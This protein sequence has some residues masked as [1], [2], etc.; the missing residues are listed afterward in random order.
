MGLAIFNEFAFEFILEEKASTGTY[1]LRFPDDSLFRHNSRSPN[2][3]KEKSRKKVC[4]LGSRIF[5][6]FSMES[7]LFNNGKYIKIHY[8]LSIFFSIICITLPLTYSH[9]NFR[10]HCMSNIFFAINGY[11]TILH[12][13]VPTFMRPPTLNFKVIINISIL[14]TASEELATL[15]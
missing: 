8:N 5:L 1:M 10:K 2:N 4:K 9:Q 7:V 15:R 14:T 3:M 11:V 12:V 13:Y 6:I